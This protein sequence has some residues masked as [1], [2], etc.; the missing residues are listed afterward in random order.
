MGMSHELR[1]FQHKCSF[2]SV[3]CTMRNYQII[4]YG[5]YG[6]TGRLIAEECRA[7][8]MG[9]LL[10][11]RDPVK[12]KLQSEHSG[13]PFEVAD[14]N[15]RP[16][17]LNLLKKGK[18]IIHCGGPFQFTARQMAEACLETGTHY[19]DIAGEY[20][21]FELLAQYDSRA[22]DN[23]ILIMPGVGF[24]VVPSDCLALFLKKRLPTATHLQLAFAMSKGGLSRGTS[25]TMIEGMG[26]GGMIRQN[27]KLTPL[28]LGDKVME[29]D[30]GPFKRKALCI[31]WGDIAT[32]WRSTGIPNIEVYSAVPGNTIRAAKASRWF[33]RLLRQRW[34]KD[35]LLKRVDQR[36]TGPDQHKR[37]SGRSYLWGKVWDQQGNSQEARLDTISGYSLTAK[38]AVLVAEKILA[39]SARPGYFTPAQYFGEELI[40]S[41]ET[42]K[43]TV[44][45][46]T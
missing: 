8:S 10:S 3:H 46:E 35:Y 18:L 12:L 20:P 31:P 26:Y 21:V 29:I 5:S 34:I 27:G 7:L 28:P 45:P 40:L 38:T 41:I 14:I 9:V 16:A 43:L 2:H 13:Y 6:Y 32:A 37:E 33:N 39:G 15:D 42:T 11:G 23:G 17:L 30:F 22:K 44:V 36:I 19:T 24:D 4:L 1:N 25:K